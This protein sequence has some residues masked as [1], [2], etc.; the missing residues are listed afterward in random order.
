MAWRDETVLVLGLAM[1]VA[2]LVPGCPSNEDP[3]AAVDAARTRRDAPEEDAYLDP[4]IDAFVY[5]DDAYLD[6]STDAYLLD[7]S[8]DAVIVTVPDVGRMD[9][10]HIDAAPD[11]GPVLGCMGTTMPAEPCTYDDECRERGFSRCNLPIHAV[12]L[13]PMP[14]FATEPQ[15]AVNADCMGDAGPVDGADAGPFGP[16]CNVHEPQCACPRYVCEPE[17]VARCTEGFECPR[18]SVCAPSEA[19]ADEHGCAPRTCTTT[20]DCDCGFCTS[21]GL[22]AD[23]VGTCE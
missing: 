17:P 9:A 12:S 8:I 22:C 20:A 19:R 2:G 15:C 6:P 3:D 18:N 5:R 1:G 23:G 14:C 11:G 10:P 21:L 4:T 16:F 13:C 7:T